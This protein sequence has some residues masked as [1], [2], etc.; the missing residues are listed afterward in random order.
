MPEQP[1]LHFV[2][3][4]QD[5]LR[6]D[7]TLD[8]GGRAL[9]AVN[10]ITFLKNPMGDNLDHVML[11][12]CVTDV[13]LD[14]SSAVAIKDHR[15]ADLERGCHRANQSALHP[16]QCGSPHAGAKLA[17]LLRE[18]ADLLR[19]RRSAPKAEWDQTIETL[20]S[21]ATQLSHLSRAKN[22]IDH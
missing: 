16:Q 7:Q 13:L 3:F 17:H 20:E 12:N 9:T 4:I 18:T 19:R 15:I 10:I 5:V 1:H 21:V 14:V 22:V 6:H 2:Q 11:L 8:I